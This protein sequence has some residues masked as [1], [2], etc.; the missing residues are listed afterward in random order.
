MGVLVFN[1]LCGFCG[2]DGWCLCVGDGICCGWVGGWCCVGCFGYY[3]YCWI[4]VVLCWVVGLVCCGLVGFFL[5]WFFRIV[6]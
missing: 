6:G 5:V 4:L 1:L 2:W 3:D